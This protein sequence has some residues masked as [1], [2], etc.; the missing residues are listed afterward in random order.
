MPT[1]PQTKKKH[2]AGSILKK[3]L[4]E[5]I[6]P[7]VFFMITFTLLLITEALVEAD[8]GIDTIE[9]GKAVIGAL[10]VG[11]VLL[12]V[13]IFPF[14][15]RY[16]AR[17]LI[18]NT[19][20]KTVI[21]NVAALIVRYLEALIGLWIDKGSLG[22]ANDALFAEIHW[23]H[24]WLIQ[25]WLAVLFLVYCGGAELSRAIGRDKL[26]ALFFGPRPAKVLPGPT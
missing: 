15:D 25:L 4:R 18:W 6:P 1:S 2:H 8:Y 13:D 24:F 14:I 16:P 9:F 7:T 26:I 12:I 3:E 20:W 19:L 23:P 10:I 11:K 17:P 5:L 21:Y 22:A